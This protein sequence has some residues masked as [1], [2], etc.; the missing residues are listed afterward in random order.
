MQFTKSKVQQLLLLPSEDEDCKSPV[1]LE[2]GVDLESVGD[3]V[4]G[5]DVGGFVGDF[6][7][8]SDPFLGG[9]H[10]LKLFLSSRQT[11]PSQ[12]EFGSFAHPFQRFLQLC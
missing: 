6:F 7:S 3:P 8:L 10:I 4:A 9:R 12:Q 1:S 11:S 5:L 2:E